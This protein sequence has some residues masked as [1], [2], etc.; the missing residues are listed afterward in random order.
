M[1]APSRALESSIAVR[2]NAGEGK[3]AG[4]E[5]ETET[6]GV[7]MSGRRPK[8]MFEM[9]LLCVLGKLE[10]TPNTLLLA[11]AYPKPAVECRFL[12]WG[13]GVGLRVC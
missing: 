4:W 13:R 10:H 8:L 2:S 9:M 3:D 11:E 5:W 7:V 12:S 6:G 1:A